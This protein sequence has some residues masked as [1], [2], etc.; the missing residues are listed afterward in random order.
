MALVREL[1]PQQCTFVP[2]SAEQATSDHGWDL[3]AR[4]RRGCAPLIAEARALGV[5]VSLFMDADPAAMARAPAIGADRVELYTEPYAQAYGTPRQAQALAR[6]AAAARGGAARSASASTPATT[7]TATTS[8]TSSRGVPGVLEVSIGHALI[9]DALELG[10][11]ETVRAYLPRASSARRRDDLRH[12]HRHLRHPPHPRR[13]WRGAATASPSACSAPHELAVFRARRAELEERGVRYLATRFSAK[14]AF[15]KAIGLGMRMPMTW[16]GCEIVNRPSGKPEIR[17]HG[18]LADWF[19]ARGLCA[20]VTVTDE[21]DYAASF[22]VVERAKRRP[23]NR[24]NHAPVVLDVAG[25]ALDADDRRRLAH[26]LTGGVILFAR[27]WRDRTQLTELVAEIKSIRARRADLRRPRRRPRAA[28]SQ[29]RLHRAAA[30]ARARR[31]VDGRRRRGA[32]AAR[33]APSR[34]RP[35]PATCSAPSCAPAASTSASR[36]CSTST[37]AR[38]AS[39]ATAPS[40]ATRASSRCS[41][42]A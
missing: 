30:D 13:R 22:V 15:S 18:V 38:A 21:A 3:A 36:R 2:D 40:T 4:R 25:L 32:G 10:M 1:R 42:R 28:L 23:M 17:L 35:P 24:S 11:A 33:C 34:R 14:E 12:R 39:S 16:R 41:P 9:A 26:P 27:N 31:D 6:F 5:R 7:S 20:H 19:A 29:R 8:A 37:T